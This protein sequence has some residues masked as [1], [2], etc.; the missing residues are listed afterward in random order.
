MNTKRMDKLVSL[1]RE[2]NLDG[3]ALNPGPSLKY[4]TGLEFHLMERPTI[5]LVTV[6]G[7]SAII[8]PTM[9]KGKLQEGSPLF[10]VFSYG[11]DPSTWQIIFDQA[12]EKLGIKDG[13]IGVEAGRMRFLELAYLQK[14]LPGV[15]FV[16]GEEV[17]AGLRIKKDPDEIA[18]M[19]TAA[20]IAQ[21]ALIKMLRNIR[22]GLSLI[23][24]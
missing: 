7:S 4:L 12:V 11:D 5:L 13:K 18:K 10:H 23:H 14:A 22:Q 19:R 9:E 2:H 20:K 6:V 3:L 17:I 16:N 24:I 8:L 21:E 15:E 1:I